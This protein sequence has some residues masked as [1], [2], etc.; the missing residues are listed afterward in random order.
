MLIEHTYIRDTVNEVEDAIKVFSSLCREI[1][2]EYIKDNCPSLKKLFKEDLDDFLRTLSG[3]KQTIWG[4]DLEKDALIDK[5][6]DYEVNKYTSPEWIRKIFTGYSEIAP[7]SWGEDGVILQVGEDKGYVFELGL[8]REKTGE[9]TLEFF[10]WD[11]CM[12]TKDIT[13][14]LQPELAEEIAFEK[15]MEETEE[16]Y[17]YERDIASGAYD[18]EIDY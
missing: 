15:F 16:Q 1:P 3:D 12:W 4:V 13:N 9:Y 17:Q 11:D 6:T 2:V 7:E 10:L 5:I 18:M 14:I 8:Y